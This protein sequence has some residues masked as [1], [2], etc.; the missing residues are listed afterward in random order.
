M[1]AK[2]ISSE[3][4]ATETYIVEIDG[5]KYTY[6][7][8]LDAKGKSMDSLLY[9]DRGCYLDDPALMEQAQKMVDAIPHE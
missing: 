9:D 6:V 3:T 4:P 8:Y 1:A 5:K 7:D 2:L